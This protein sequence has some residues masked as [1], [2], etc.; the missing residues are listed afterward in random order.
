MNPEIEKTGGI[1][2]PDGM[3]LS[4]FAMR[5]LKSVAAW[6]SFLA[7]VGTLVDLGKDRIRLDDIKRIVEAKNRSE[8]GMSVPAH[9]LYLAGIEYAE[10][11][12]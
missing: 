9:G 1:A 11:L 10:G 5:N 7:I 3:N 4:L 8:A 6:A 12:V 2:E